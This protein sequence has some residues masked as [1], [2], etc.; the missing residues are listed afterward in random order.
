MGDEEP[1]AVNNPNRIQQR[2]NDNIADLPTFYGR[3]E[4]DTVTLKY[5]VARIDQGVTTLGWTQAEAYTYFTNSIKATAANWVDHHVYCHP[6][7]IHEWNVIKPFFRK[8]FG[9]KTDPMVF[10]STMFG[11]K[12]TNFDNNL[13]DYSSA[14]SKCQT[15]HNEKWVDQTEPLPLAHGLTTAQILECQTAL[16]RRGRRI[17]EDF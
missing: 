8:A 6:D 17:H 5:F 13:Y 16:N 11:L 7:D 1:Q 9:D 3:P 10:A 14:V 12:L 2:I 4:K 15:L